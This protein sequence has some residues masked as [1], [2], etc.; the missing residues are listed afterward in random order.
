[1][2][3]L[4]ENLK[5]S[6]SRR[7]FIEKFVASATLAGLAGPTFSK[8][9]IPGNNTVTGELDD[10]FNQIKGAHRAVYDV[11][12]P[13]DLYPFAWPKV[14]LMTNE[15]AGAKPGDS[16]VVVVLRHEG[17]PFAMENRLWEKYHFGE[18]FKYNDPVTKKPSLR[19]PFWQPGDNDFVVPGVGP[20]Q[21]GINQLQ[22]SGVMFCVCNMAITVY[23]AAIA[24]SM[25]G[26]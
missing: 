18:L 11:P 2:K 9:L 8:S 4:N 14:F 25:N 20:V 6:N 15:M 3:P 7:K 21:I 22:E 17:I 12:S 10:W 5:N 24:Q 16:S 19:N 26:N 23:S 13:N 1:M